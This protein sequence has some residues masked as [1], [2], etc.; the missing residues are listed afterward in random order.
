MP[1]P[2]DI[3]FRR[4]ARDV[5]LSSRARPRHTG[6]V[7]GGHV[8]DRRA[9][10]CG[11]GSPQDPSAA[12]RSARRH[13]HRLGRADRD[14]RR[15]C[16][17]RRRFPTG[18]GWEISRDPQ[19]WPLCQGARVP[20]RLSERMAAH[21]DQPSRRHRRLQQ[22][23]PELGGGRP[24]EMG[25]ARLCLRARRLARLRL[26]ARVYRPLVAARDQGFLRLH[27]MGRRAALVEWQGRA[28]R[29]LLLRH[30]PVARGHAATA[31]SR[32]PVHLGRLR[33][34]LP[35]TDA[36]RRHPLHVP[37]ELVRH[38]GEDRAIWRGRAWQAQPRARR[39]GLRAG[40][41]ERDGAR[42]AT[43]AISARKFSHTRSTTTITKLARRSGRR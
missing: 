43:A 8:I 32:R 17:A 40:N 30:Q 4:H 1:L 33:R 5:T 25:A 9:G 37:G 19:L 18:E 23:V 20:G 15:P 24:G 11:G 29:H 13:V 12:Q 27:R 26:L 28:Q 42:R 3:L 38:A 39:A 31:A 22:Q 36:P 14:G 10:A 41:P 21:G 16:A 35:R 34:L 6:R 7:E 2:H